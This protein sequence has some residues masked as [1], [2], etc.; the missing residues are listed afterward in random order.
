MIELETD[1]GDSHEFLH[2]ASQLITGAAIATDL[3]PVYG[4]WI[5][6]VD[7]FFGRSWLGFRGKLLGMAG[8]RNRSLK[9]DLAIPPFYSDRVLSVRYF[10]RNDD[11]EWVRSKLPFSRSLSVVSSK[12]NVNSKIHLPGVYAW[13]STGSEEKSKGALMAYAIKKSAPN[14][15]WYTMWE[16]KPPWKLVQNIGIGVRTCRHFINLGATH[17][18]N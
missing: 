18:A 15:A 6:R 11:G 13:Y 2:L 9:D 14:A 5:A 12:Y 3:P 8:C 10:A 16:N 1:K 4:V 17:A 7:G